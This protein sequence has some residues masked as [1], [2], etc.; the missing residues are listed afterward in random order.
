MGIE[1][2]RNLCGFYGI[3]WNTGIPY[4]KNIDVENP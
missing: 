4:V 3:E 1:V 2:S